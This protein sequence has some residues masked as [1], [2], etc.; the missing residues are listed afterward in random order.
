MVENQTLDP[1]NPDSK[2]NPV[3]SDAQEEALQWQEQGQHFDPTRLAGD[4]IIEKAAASGNI[5]DTEGQD[6]DVDALDQDFR[7]NANAL[8]DAGSWMQVDSAVSWGPDLQSRN[9]AEL[10]IV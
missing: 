1:S 6:H 3:I 9:S 7:N 5:T 2:S 10:T 4:K 8:T